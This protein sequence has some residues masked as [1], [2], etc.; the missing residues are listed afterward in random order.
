[1]ETFNESSLDLVNQGYTLMAV[2]NYEEAA[3][4]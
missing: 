4:V 1:M 3:K 2:E